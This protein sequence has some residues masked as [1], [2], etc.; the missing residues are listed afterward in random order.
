M[1]DV[2]S[3][4]ISPIMGPARRRAT[5]QLFNQS[6]TRRITQGLDP[7]GM[8]PI[9]SPRTVSKRSRTGAERIFPRQTKRWVLNE[10]F[11]FLGGSKRWGIAE[12]GLAS[13][14]RY[15]TIRSSDWKCTVADTPRAGR[16]NSKKGYGAKEKYEIPQDKRFHGKRK[17]RTNVV[18]PYQH[19]CVSSVTMHVYANQAPADVSTAN[20]QR[21]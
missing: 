10:S 6:E 13:A 4:N 8:L 11:G 15:E 17:P 21:C 12:V 9:F 16:I 20:E 18:A 7:V 5:L 1:S 14:T 2:P 3:V 19:A